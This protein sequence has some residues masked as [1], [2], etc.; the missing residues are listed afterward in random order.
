MQLSSTD[1]QCGGFSGSASCVPLFAEHRT[2]RSHTAWS[3]P[4]SYRAF[5]CAYV[6]TSLSVHLLLH[7]VS[8][9]WPLYCVLQWTE[10]CIYLSVS[11]ACILGTSH[12]VELLGDQGIQFNSGALHTP[13]WNP[14][15]C[16]SPS[17]GEWGFLSYHTS[18]NTFPWEKP[19]WES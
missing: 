3:W 18:S 6:H 17:N 10:V 9:S 19:G 1:E 5:H 16:T 14:G 12:G 8:M 15:L 7:T 4:C 2:V 11:M 13:S